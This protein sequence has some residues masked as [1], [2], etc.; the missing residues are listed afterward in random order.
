MENLAR[1]S[2]LLL[3][4]IQECSGRCSSPSYVL[5][6]MKRRLIAAEIKH[7][8]MRCKATSLI[9]IKHEPISAD[10]IGPTVGEEERLLRVSNTS[11][12]QL[13]MKCKGP[14]WVYHLR[15]QRRANNAVYTLKPA[16]RTSAYTWDMENRR[17]TWR[18]GKQTH[19]ERSSWSLQRVTRNARKR[20]RPR[21]RAQGCT[22]ILW[23][24]R[25]A[26]HIWSDGKAVTSR[27]VID[28][29]KLSILDNKY[30]STHA[31]GARLDCR[32]C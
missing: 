23:A 7:I 5:F 12:E 9:N 27:D 3:S 11:E 20:P 19:Q 4:R 28:L 1:I 26:H 6:D 32:K 22:C 2:E 10:L 31:R 16:E 24:F 21:I 14:V 25:C 30:R 17:C 13:C 8:S 29:K 15:I 18:I